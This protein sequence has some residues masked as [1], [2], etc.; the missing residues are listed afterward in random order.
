MGGLP[1][2][3]H[4]LL[5][6]IHGDPSAGGSTHYGTAFTLTTEQAPDPHTREIAWCG[7][8]LQ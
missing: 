2:E 6:G 8:H 7:R 4:P 1:G 5:A 3:Q